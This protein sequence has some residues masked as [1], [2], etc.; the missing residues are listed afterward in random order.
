MRMSSCKFRSCCLFGFNVVFKNFSV[1]SRRCLVATGGSN[2][3]LM[4]LMTKP[5]KRT[6]RQAKTQ[7]SLGI[8][9]GSSESSLGAHGILLVLS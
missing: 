9:P 6:L 8:R 5:I 3:H 1:I 2:A 7:I 4:C